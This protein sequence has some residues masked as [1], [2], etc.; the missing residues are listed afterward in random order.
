MRNGLI[1]SHKC[2]TA[3]VIVICT[4]R[5]VSQSFV[6]SIAIVDSTNSPMAIQYT[7][8]HVHR[9]YTNDVTQILYTIY[10]Y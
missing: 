4:A 6:Q 10:R 1:L 3:V 2:S 8:I 7:D 9:A 5:Q